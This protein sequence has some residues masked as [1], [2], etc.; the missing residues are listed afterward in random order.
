MALMLLILLAGC[1]PGTTQIER[2]KKDNRLIVVTRNGPATYY[3]GPFGPA[4]LEYDLVSK[5]ADYLGVQLEIITVNSPSRA[6]QLLEAGGADL[7]AAG[8]TI[9]EARKKFFRFSTGYLDVTP[10]LVYRIG[11]RRPEKIEDIVGADIRVAADSPHVK[12]LE[13]LH[14]RH[15][16][17]SW[18]ESTEHSTGELMRLVRSQ[19]IDY[20]VA[21]STEIKFKQHFYPELAVAFDLGSPHKTGW[22]LHKSTDYSLLSETQAFFARINRNG[23][24]DALISRYF[25][26]MRPLDY[27]GTR[28]FMQD[29]DNRLPGYLRD[30]K[31]SAEKYD[32]DW[33]LLAAVS[34]QESHWDENAV[35]PTGVKG[36]MMLTGATANFMGIENRRDPKQSIYG[37][38]KYLRYM[39]DKIPSRIMEPERTWMALAAYNV[40]YGHLEDARKITQ[41]LGSNPDKWTDV[42]RHLPL[43]SRKEWYS[44]TQHG[45]A[46]GN[47]P[48]VYV[49]N[50][51]NYLDLLVWY[52]AGIELMEEP[53][54]ASPD[55]G[56]P[57]AQG[58][59]FTA[60]AAPPPEKEKSDQAL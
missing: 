26:R 42:Q 28:M 60:P 33:R 20:T 6:L 25:E 52:E 2:I 15:P 31:K 30:F 45:Y 38:A 59:V 39:I 14:I 23:I 49:S 10:Q 34:Y 24:L 12:A 47:E 58:A 41:G 56:S 13:H 53:S 51:R 11:S 22:A 40:G 18:H 21:G 19:S 44:R 46:R 7:A 27:V 43:L 16:G 29:I 32:L 55:I 36:L 48:V 54:E 5:F 50:I 57:V 1:S 35:S 4:G 37:G 8:L 17:L 3:E 9:T